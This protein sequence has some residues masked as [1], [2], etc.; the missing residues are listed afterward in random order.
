MSTFALDQIQAQL[1]HALA[2]RY[3]D[4]PGDAWGVIKRESIVEVARLLKEKLGFKLFVSMDAVDRLHLPP[5]EQDPR[6]EVLYFLRNV[7]RNESVRLKVRVNENEDVPSI[8]HVY[9]G[10]EWGERFVWDFYGVV[11]AGGIKRRM[12]MYEE[13]VGHPLR[14]DYPLRGR[15]SLTPERPIKDIFRGPGTNGAQD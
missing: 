3:K 9:Q 5:E 2:D 8:R 12:L 13:F 4:R 11:F 7:E 10:A 6:F 14:K 15:Q 1:P